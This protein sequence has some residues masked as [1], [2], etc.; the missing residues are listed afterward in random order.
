M[1]AKHERRFLGWFQP[2]LQTSSLNSCPQKILFVKTTLCRAQALKNPVYN[3]PVSLLCFSCSAQP[4]CLGY[5]TTLLTHRQGL[6]QQDPCF[7][8]HPK[9]AFIP[10]Q[11]CGQGSI[12]HDPTRMEHTIN[13]PPQG[14]PTKE[15]AKVI[16]TTFPVR[17]NFSNEGELL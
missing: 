1:A 8:P 17:M 2:L 6:C 10:L 16:P 3:L 9:D 11:H 7:Q 15:A 13:L 5:T 14:K 4:F 12:K